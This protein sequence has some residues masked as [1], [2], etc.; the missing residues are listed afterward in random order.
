[1]RKNMT[2]NADIVAEAQA[3]AEQAAKVAADVA[4]PPAPPAPVVALTPIQKMKAERY[5]A[6]VAGTPKSPD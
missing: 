6:V 2:D 5:A 4:T 1:M 3:L